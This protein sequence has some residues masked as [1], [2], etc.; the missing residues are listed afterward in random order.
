M[1]G[2]AARWPPLSCPT[3]L[4][5]AWEAILQ[6]ASSGWH[7]PVQATVALHPLPLLFGFT[8]CLP[9]NIQLSPP[10]QPGSHRPSPGCLPC[11]PR[12]DTLKL[13][14]S[15][16]SL[17][18]LRIS[19]QGPLRVVFCLC[20]DTSGIYMLSPNWNRFAVPSSCLQTSQFPHLEGGDC[21]FLFSEETEA[22]RRQEI[23]PSH[24][25]K[26][27]QVFQCTISQNFTRALLKNVLLTF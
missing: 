8:K 25:G 4:L 16:V 15:L 24:S 5:Q 9:P 2:G 17:P 6:P 27:A 11:S 10:S 26:V 21:E 7:L 18:T 20:I 3:A 14:W 13:F 12:A 23:C 1:P 19:V 22:W